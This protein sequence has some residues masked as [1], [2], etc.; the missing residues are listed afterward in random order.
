MQ[1]LKFARV[2]AGYFSPNKYSLPLNFQLLS[3]ATH[4]AQ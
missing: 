2:T 1:K 3:T 4:Q